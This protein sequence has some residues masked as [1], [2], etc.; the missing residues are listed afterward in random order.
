MRVFV[1]GATGFIG[2]LVT[3]ELV[4]A[5][6]QVLGLTRSETGAAALRAAGADVHY[7]TLEDL[8]SLREGAAAADA[9]IHLAF[10]HDF[11][12][13]VEHCENDRVVIE[14]LGEVLA[15]SSRPLIITSGTAVAYTPGRLSTEDDAP[16]SPAPRILSEQA[17]DAVLAKGVDVRVVRLPQVHDPLKQ[18]LISP[19]ALIAKEKAVSA[20]VG[21]GAG[22][23]PAAHVSDVAVLYR[24]VLE[25]GQKGKRY[26]AVAEE[27]VSLKDI[28]DVL[29]KGLGLPV[30][31]ITAEEAQAHFGWLGLFVSGDIGASGALTQE[32]LGWKPKGPSLL[33]DLAE[34]RFDGT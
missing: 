17:A 24:L 27:G 29:G 31:S 10:N 28:A 13:W 9:V 21:E 33:A 32:R 1:T 16:N 8:G 23:W 19:L 26:N 30:A 6:Y 5:G 15:G 18:G 14:A 22:R 20:Y 12:K 25:K 2:T 34:G 4:G 3:K 7:G 11:S